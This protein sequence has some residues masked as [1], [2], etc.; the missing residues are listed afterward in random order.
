MS[1]FVIK[2]PF[3]SLF[4]LNEWVNDERTENQKICRRSPYH[5]CLIETFCELWIFGVPG[6]VIV[7]Q[8]NSLSFLHKKLLL[9][10]KWIQ[11]TQNLCPQKFS[12]LVSIVLKVVFYGQAMANRLFRPNAENK[13]LLRMKIVLNK[14]T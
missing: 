12:I 1:D 6:Q 7:L 10:S 5:S 13:R 8:I 14:F 11:I 4:V 2:I 9:K 3:N